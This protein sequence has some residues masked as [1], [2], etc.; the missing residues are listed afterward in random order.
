MRT[1]QARI[2]TDAAYPVADETHILPDREAPVWLTLRGK[3]K[4]SSLPV[5]HME[6]I[7]DRLPGLFG[8]FKPYGPTGL[9]LAD[10][11]PING[12]SVRGNVLN[13]ESNE[14]ASDRIAAANDP[15]RTSSLVC[16]SDGL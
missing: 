16:L 14:I 2:E 3:Q 5:R 7:I 6:V 4:I 13:S 15:K 12:V 1:E 10:R 11:R 9:L 8:D